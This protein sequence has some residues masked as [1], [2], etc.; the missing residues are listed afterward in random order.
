MVREQVGVNALTRLSQ[1]VKGVELLFEEIR[2]SLVV[3][4]RGQELFFGGTLNLTWGI[5]EAFLPTMIKGNTISKD[6]KL[7]LTDIEEEGGG[8]VDNET[9]SL[10]RFLNDN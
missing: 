3:L 2:S 4:A 10:G 1:Q 7:C 5:Q 8:G 6:N 9:S